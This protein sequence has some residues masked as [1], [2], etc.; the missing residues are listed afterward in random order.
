M[1]EVRT[2]QKGKQGQKTKKTER[3]RSEWMKAQRVESRNKNDFLTLPA[4]SKSSVK[5]PF[6]PRAPL[7]FPFSERFP[8]AKPQ[9]RSN[10]LFLAFC[11]LW[12]SLFDPPLFLF[13]CL[14]CGLGLFRCFW[15]CVTFEVSRLFVL[16]HCALYMFPPVMSSD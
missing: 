2:E 8:A 4:Q 13:C 16:R 12:P 3:N 5:V 14:R 11:C 9:T 7:D 15:F 1:Q 10:E 6:P